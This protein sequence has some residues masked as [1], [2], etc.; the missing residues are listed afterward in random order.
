M[1]NKYVKDVNINVK[2]VM[3]VWINFITI[4]IILV[5]VILVKIGMLTMMVE[6]KVG[7]NIVV[8]LVNPILNVKY[9]NK[10]KYNKIYILQNNHIIV[11]NVYPFVNY[12]MKIK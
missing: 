2:Y 3:V 9:V 5:V 6:Q 7:M 4:I 8:L 10:K 12:V 1:I 11:M